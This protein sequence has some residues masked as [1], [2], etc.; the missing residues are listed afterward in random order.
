MI[1]LQLTET[2]DEGGLL[3]YWLG[4]IANPVDA[5]VYVH[6]CDHLNF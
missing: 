1:D 4:N 2:T 3:Y 5:Y 6:T